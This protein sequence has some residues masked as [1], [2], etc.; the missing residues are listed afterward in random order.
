MNNKMAKIY[1]Y[2]QL[3][4]KN[5]LSKQEQ[6]LNHRYGDHL[7][8]YQLGEGGGRRREKVQGLRST[9]WQLQNSRG[10]VKYSIGKGVPKN[11]YERL[12]DMINGVWTA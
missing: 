11:L 3:S 9:N 2:Q 6:K 4:L 1:I 10:D 12:M 5:K 7:E 8:G